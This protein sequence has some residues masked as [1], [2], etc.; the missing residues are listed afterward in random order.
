MFVGTKLLFSFDYRYVFLS[1][2]F[3]FLNGQQN[4][5]LLKTRHVSWYKMNVIM[6]RACV[7]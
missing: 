5:K 2:L 7:F 3:F 6:L 4:K 1:D